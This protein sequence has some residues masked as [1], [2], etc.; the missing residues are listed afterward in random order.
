[1]ASLGLVFLLWGHVEV[2][3]AWAVLSGL[4]SA[5]SYA[6]YVM[7]SARVQKD[8]RPISSA[9][10][11]ITF[12]AIALSLFHAPSAESISE[13]TTSQGL[14]VL[15]IALVCTVLPL[16]LELAALQKLRSKEVALLM[17]IEPLTATAL[18]ILVLRESLGPLQSLGA[19]LIVTALVANTL[20]DKKAL[21]ESASK[22]ADALAKQTL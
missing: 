16:S 5:I 8:V 6:G 12:G 21:Q 11:V 4:A 20:K 3:N 13:I 19:F 9:L 22:S 18:G 17:M 7:I 10:Y 14:L 1:M 15:G 2:K